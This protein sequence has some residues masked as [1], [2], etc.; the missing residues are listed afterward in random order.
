M[1]FCGRCRTDKPVDGFNKN[2]SRKD[3]LATQCK[4]CHKEYQQEYQKRGYVKKRQAKT[5]LERYH[6]LTSEEKKKYNSNARRKAWHLM[7][8][9]K[10]TLEWYSETVEAQGGRC[11]I[12][13]EDPSDQE[14]LSVDHD[15]S[16][17][18]GGK[19]CGNCVRGLLCRSCNF[20][21][22][23]LEKED[24]VQ[25]GMSYLKQWMIEKENN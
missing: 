13:E 2:S 25:R 9:Y 23:V 4:D 14:F 7:G 12:C 10:K 1:K 22:G 24:F 15:H 17:C 3:G 16:C 18:P 21:L 19:S 20:A 6:R 5:A 8:S 11:A